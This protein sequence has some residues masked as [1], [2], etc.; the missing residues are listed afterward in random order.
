[1]HTVCVANTKIDKCKR[2]FFSYRCCV[3]SNKISLQKL[4]YAVFT[5]RFRIIVSDY[6]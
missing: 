1:M 5:S 2:M 6:K 4:L 3:F